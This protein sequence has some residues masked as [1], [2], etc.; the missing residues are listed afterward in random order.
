METLER[1]A[2]LSLALVA[3]LSRMPFSVDSYVQ[4]SV[5]SSRSK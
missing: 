4:L 1:V 2:V 5:L 3:E